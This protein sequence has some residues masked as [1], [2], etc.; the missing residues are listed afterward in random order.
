MDWTV[1][2]VEDGE[3]EAWLAVRMRIRLKGE[4]VTVLAWWAESTGRELEEDGRMLISSELVGRSGSSSIRESVSTAQ[5]SS[6]RVVTPDLEFRPDPL[7]LEVFQAEFAPPGRLDRTL[8][9]D[10]DVERVD[11]WNA[12]LKGSVEEGGRGE[13]EVASSDGKIEEL[14]GM[15]RDPFEEEHPAGFGIC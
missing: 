13:N 4:S 11:D 5:R 6:S 1:G 9:L 15:G 7:V 10:A 3:M 12:D 14:L 2:W 8:A